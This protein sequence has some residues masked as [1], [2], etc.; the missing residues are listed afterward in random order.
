[1]T[2]SDTAF[3]CQ[4]TVPENEA[5]ILDFDGLFTDCEALDEEGKH[6]YV[7]AYATSLAEHIGQ[8]R[9][10]TR[11][12]MGQIEAAIRANPEEHGMRFEGHIVAPGLADPY[13]RCRSIAEVIFTRANRFHDPV[14]RAEVLNELYGANYL[15]YVP[16]LRPG[17]EELICEI[18]DLREDGPIHIVT[19][20]RTEHVSGRIS[21]V[22]GF[23][24]ADLVWGQAG[25]FELDID[26][27]QYPW[28]SNFPISIQVPGMH[29]RE[30]YLRRGKYRKL[31]SQLINN[32]KTPIERITVAGD[33][34]ELDLAMWQH[35]G[36]RV[37]CLET[38]NTPPY[39]HQWLPTRPNAHMV[40][41]IAELVQ[42]LNTPW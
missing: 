36:A 20:S 33:I 18:N 15:K 10:W 37:I 9:D 8:P 26:G 2:T 16:P 27:T 21:E 1:M 39:L 14:R 24:N 38:E 25:K 30:V 12:L 11:G 3:E 32:R 28:E 31:V 17:A 13:L 5:V 4:F 22:S 7:E 19:N 35:L 41:S 42:I 40:T 34:W 6:P 29:R 23:V